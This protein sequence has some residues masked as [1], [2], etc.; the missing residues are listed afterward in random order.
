MDCSRVAGW[1]SRAVFLLAFMVAASGALAQEAPP[2]MSDWG[3]ARTVLREQYGVTIGLNYIGEVLDVASGGIRREGSFEGRFEGVVDVDLARLAGWMGASAHVKGFQI[4][5]GGRN[6]A[7]NAGSLFDPSNIDALPTTRLF[8][9]WFQQNFFGDIV[10]IRAGQLAADDEFLTSPTAGGLING[11]FGWAAINAAN[12]RSGGPAYPLAAPGVRLQVKPSS[13]VT[14]LAA[15]FSGDPAGK[16]CTINPQ[17]CNRHGTTFS[18]SGGALWIAEAQLAV[19]AS[20][21]AAG[22]PGVYKI[23]A[24]HATADYLDQRLGIDPA[25]GQV[26]SLADSAMPDAIRLRGNSGIY[27]VADQMVWRAGDRAINVFLR[28]GATPSD[29]N[30]ISAYVDGGVGIKG[31]FDGRPYDLLTL[32]VARGE[33]GSHARGLDRDTLAINGPLVPI[34]NYETVFELSYIARLT[35]WWSIQPNLQY[36][37]H[38]GGRVL[39][40]L[41][42]TRVIGNAFIAGART[43]INF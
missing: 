29:R 5:N 16:N 36:L 12:I 3:G 17:E 19:N 26:L 42:P 31:M 27:G 8:T 37:V 4:H 10:S 2:V 33:I 14:L 39:N 20:P 13:D 38:P 28:A 22:L 15:V 41:D 9:A 43:T 32:G 24:W 40:P 6:A 23:G 7:D 30:L 34:R 21:D 35:P 25:T 1:G 18:F 11:T